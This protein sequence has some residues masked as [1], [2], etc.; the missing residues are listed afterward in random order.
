MMLHHHARSTPEQTSVAST[1]AALTNSTDAPLLQ[2][3]REGAA[4]VW[5]EQVVQQ[6]PGLA[7][8][9]GGSWHDKL[10]SRTTTTT[11]SSTNISAISDNSS[12]IAGTTSDSSSALV[13]ATSQP[14]RIAAIKAAAAKP[15]T[16]LFMSGLFFTPRPPDNCDLEGVPLTCRLSNDIAEARFT[17]ATSTTMVTDTTTTTTVT[18]SITPGSPHRHGNQLSLLP[19]P[20]VTPRR[21]AQQT[22]STTT[23]RAFLVSHFPR[24]FLR[25]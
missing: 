20:A 24:R 18:V 11:S 5:K 13:P 6:L 1:G 25:S 21:P 7:P 8:R 3:L 4:V 9:Y 23:S 16:I 14:D 10:D 15:V 12:S 22:C 2:R 17:T 19:P